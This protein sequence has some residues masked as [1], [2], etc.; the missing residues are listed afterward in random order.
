MTPRPSFAAKA[1]RFI[2]VGIGASLTIS[3]LV[4]GMAAFQLIDA[5]AA[6][7]IGITRNEFLAGYG[8]MLFC[9]LTLVWLG[10]RRRQ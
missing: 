4:G 3:A 7:A 6:E 2:L 9:G 5:S 1:R 8:V 10:L